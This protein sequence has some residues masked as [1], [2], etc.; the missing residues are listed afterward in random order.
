MEKQVDIISMSFSILEYSPA[1][2]DAVEKAKNQGI[3]MLCSHHDQGAAVKDAWPAKFAPSTFV[4][5]SCDDY[6]YT[7]RKAETTEKEGHYK[8]QGHN[9]T[10]GVVAFVESQDRIS[11]SSVAT[12]IAAGLSSLI[13]SC[14]RL[15]LCDPEAEGEIQSHGAGCPAAWTASGSGTGSSSSG[16]CVGVEHCAGE[17]RRIVVKHYLDQ[18]RAEGGREQNF[19]LLE[20]FGEI[21]AK[22]KEGERPHADDIV[23]RWFAPRTIQEV[24][25]KNQGRI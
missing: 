23:R 17:N 4:I 9:V 16:S 3:V 10:A 22:V 15:S 20:R 8:L 24:V 1:L 12:A 11:G 6:G 18:M 19:V 25:S 7:E 21:D 2:R 13:L 14:A 5:T